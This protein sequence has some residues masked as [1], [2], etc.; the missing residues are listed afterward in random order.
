[1][2]L[3]QWLGDYVFP[4]KNIGYIQHFCQLP[5]LFGM[6]LLF[7]LFDDNDGAQDGDDG[8]HPTNGASVTSCGDAEADLE[9]PINWATLLRVLSRLCVGVNVSNLFVIH[10]VSG[11]F[12]DEPLEYSAYQAFAH[13]CGV[14]VV[15]LLLAL[16]LFLLVEAPAARL[17]DGLLQAFSSS[18]S[19]RPRGRRKRK[20]KSAPAAAG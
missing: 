6:A 14:V 12:L 18:D 2:D 19:Q 16:V 9:A 4:R 5:H 15:S 17:V 11:F 13:S 10:A 3:D 20:G 8:G 1:L 7:L